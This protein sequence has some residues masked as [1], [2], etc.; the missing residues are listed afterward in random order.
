MASTAVSQAGALKATCEDDP[1]TADTIQPIPAASLRAA[2]Q[3]LAER[4]GLLAPGQ[5]LSAELLAY[6]QA[7]SRMGADIRQAATPAREWACPI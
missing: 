4:V 6:G 3:A 7:A 2:Y 1:M 5:E